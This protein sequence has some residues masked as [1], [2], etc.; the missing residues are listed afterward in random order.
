LKKIT[1]DTNLLVRAVTEDDPRQSLIA[2]TELAGAE[3]V[4]LTVPA[5]CELVWVLSRLYKIS[6]TDSA[7]AIRK[8]INGGNVVID[9][10]AVAAG[11]MVMDEGGDF[12]DGIIA[13][14][15]KRLGGAQFVSF[16]RKAISRIKM[17]GL[18]ASLLA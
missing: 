16:D 8:L 10:P 1:A 3:L 11:L 17:R 7:S 9:E 5:L 13:F 15:G 12:A 2:Q 18:E 6:P 14:E 4:A